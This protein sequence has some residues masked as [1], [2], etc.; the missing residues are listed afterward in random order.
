[1]A[2]L[3][4]PISR[5]ERQAQ[6]IENWVKHKGK[7]TV[8]GATGFGKTR[9]GTNLI[10]KILKRKP[11]YRILVVVPT[12]T[13]KEQWEEILDSLG[14]GLNCSVEVIN[15][16][17]L[18][19]TKYI[20]DFLILDEI[21]RFASDLFQ[22]VFNRVNYSLILGLTATIERLDGK[23]IIIKQYCPV[24]DEITLEECMING[25]IS[26]YKE[27][28]VLIEVDNIQEYKDLNRQFNEHFGFFNY[29]FGL[30]M[31][32][33][34]PKGY[35]A[36]IAYRDQLCPNGTKEEKSAVLKSIIYHSTA[37]MRALQ[38]RKSFINNHPKKIEIAR[39]IIDARPDAK[40]I[41]FSNNIK[42]A[43]AIGIG[44]VYSGKDTKKKG[45]A[46][47]EELQS[48]DI[49]VINTIAKA[50]EG[51]NIPDLSIAV[52]LGIDSS[53]IKAV[54]RVGRVCRAQENKQ[55]EIFN[56]VINDTAETEWFKKAHAKSQ[57]TTIDEQGLE[58]VLNYEE[59]KDGKEEVIMLLLMKKN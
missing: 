33:V 45:R 37:F 35:L 43:E 52:M 40:I 32:M 6:C 41:T 23:E 5:D 8:V 11:Q 17:V 36:R 16:I 22:Q 56:L 49:R 7:A 28:Q 39:K 48:G 58:A 51:L 21:H 1:M 34:G 50:N 26:D 44:K 10:G 2:D 46:T 15:T 30:V 47:L 24:C 9:V 55:A 14:Y 13:L 18:K 25:W 57:Y 54:Q 31:N 27:Y 20:C 19:D 53:K 3:F 12:T 29:D 59:P 4:G 42:M 38:G